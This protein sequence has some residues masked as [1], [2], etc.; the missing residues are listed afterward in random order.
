LQA[1]GGASPSAPAGAARAQAVLADEA[2]LAPPAAA[3]APRMTAPLFLDPQHAQPPARTAAPSRAAAPQASP[4]PS[5]VDPRD[6]L[7]MA[8]TE[9]QQRRGELAAAAR[10]ATQPPRPSRR[11]LVAALGLAGAVVALL[12]LSWSLRG[13]PAS[14][15]GGASAAAVTTTAA[16][17]ATTEAMT[18]ATT[19]ATTE[20]PHVRAMAVSTGASPT[21][22]CQLRVTSNIDAAVLRVA[23]RDHGP[24][25]AL[26]DVP[27]A[28]TAIELRHPRYRVATRQIEPRAGLT[29]LEVR[30]TRPLVTIKV[31]STPPGA[32]VR[33]NGRAVGATPLSTTVLAFEKAT[34]VWN[35]L[36]GATKTLQIYPQSN[37]TV[38]AATLPKLQ[39][40]LRA[41]APRKR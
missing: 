14:Q 10:A 36:G 16:A 12:A 8:P 3:G 11:R 26:V 29:E 21:P 40:Q 28:P 15:T 18:E 24:V 33:L 20:A 32:T 25:P 7:A 1:G 39:P 30:M 31:V 22:P 17:R 34:L 19:E 6:L 37:G 5:G 38:Y 2:A 9:A 35:Q 27:C 13:A 41:K 4:Y 23:G